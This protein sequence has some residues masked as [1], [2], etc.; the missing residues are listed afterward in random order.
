[1]NR[2][3]NTPSRNVVFNVPNTISWLRILS[4]IIIVFLMYGRMF[5]V[6]FVLFLLSALSD[7]FDGYIARKTKQVTNLGKVLDQMSDKILIT[8]V[9]VVFVEFG[10]VPGW[11]VV[12]IIFRD[13]L[14]SIVR[15]LASGHGSVIAA[16]FFGKLK[17]ILQMVLSIGLYIE[18]LGFSQLD[19]IN[20]VFVYAVA[21]TTVLSGV[22]Y[23][24]QNRDYL[25]N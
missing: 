2:E 23:M 15:M 10:Y 7:Y 20:A 5:I 3:K 25:N 11:L 1:M 18:I 14:V 6:A 21:I 8:S 9:L 22:I 12:L 19:L 17:T 13:T 24:Y 4:T 16:N